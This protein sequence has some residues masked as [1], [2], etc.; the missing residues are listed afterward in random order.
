MADRMIPSTNPGHTWALNCFKS[1]SQKGTVIVSGQE[2]VYKNEPGSIFGSFEYTL[3]ESRSVRDVLPCPRLTK[4]KK[5]E[6][7]DDL[8]SRMRE[9]GLIA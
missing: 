7:L 8:E 2:G 1:D 9:H 3:F 5:Q 6:L 4:K